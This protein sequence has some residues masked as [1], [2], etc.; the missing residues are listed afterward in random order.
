MQVVVAVTGDLMARARLEDAAARA[1]VRLVTA[2]T[3]SF[4]EKLHA[5]R[6]DL[7]IVDLD[8]GREKL[9]T[10]LDEARAHGFLPGRVI[11]FV[12]HVDVD[13]AEAARAVG[14]EAMAR[15]GFWRSLPG[16]L[17]GGGD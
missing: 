12:S 11:G 6:P 3:D 13:L 14:C 16:L 5:F 8:A 2:S 7:L 4:A 9:L 1:G 10:R 17:S 15:G